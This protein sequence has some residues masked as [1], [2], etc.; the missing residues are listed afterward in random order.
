MK[1][2]TIKIVPVKIEMA[3]WAEKAAKAM[4]YTQ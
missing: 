3:A 4:G 2:T 1:E